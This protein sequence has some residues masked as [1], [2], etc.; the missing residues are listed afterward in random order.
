MT[1]LSLNL[2][3]LTPPGVNNRVDQKGTTTTA[4]APVETAC[5]IACY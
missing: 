3:L 4:R 5:E 1:W 2:A